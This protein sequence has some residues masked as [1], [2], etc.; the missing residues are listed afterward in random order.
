MTSVASLV[1]FVYKRTRV[2]KGFGSTIKLQLQ[3]G[4]ELYNII[5]ERNSVQCYPIVG[6]FVARSLRLL[7]R[8]PSHSS[9][10]RSRFYSHH[11]TLLP[12]GAL[13]DETEYVYL[14][15]SR[16]VQQL[17]GCQRFRLVGAQIYSPRLKCI[18]PPGTY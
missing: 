14:F 7:A 12:T 8:L 10:P 13:R 9:R 3:T 16:G 15:W 18:R 17:I 1:Q 2:I 5:V 6:N 11:A 4:C